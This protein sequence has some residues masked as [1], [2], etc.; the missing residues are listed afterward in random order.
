MD[1]GAATRAAAAR[2]VAAVL[3]RGQTLDAALAEVLAGALAGAA[4]ETA[5]TGPF[6]PSTGAEVVDAAAGGVADR[7]VATMPG[8]DQAQVQ[9]L[10]FGAIRHHHR[11]QALLARL[12][13]RPLKDRDRLLEA[14]LSVGLF[15]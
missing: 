7:S 12:L 13:L 3:A 8:R 10:A 14:L 9:W 4:A 6:S 5:T 1:S 2:A 15:Q 11:H